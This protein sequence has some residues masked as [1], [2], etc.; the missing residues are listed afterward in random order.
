MEDVWRGR[1]L[2]LYW[3]ACLNRVG[4]IILLNFTIVVSIDNHM[5]LAN[6]EHYLQKNFIIIIGK[7]AIF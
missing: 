6:T 1:R 5:F 4:R 3:G 2:G 7:T